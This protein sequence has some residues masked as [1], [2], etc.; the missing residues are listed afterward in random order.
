MIF[1][2]SSRINF[3]GKTNAVRTETCRR[4][5]CSSKIGQKSTLVLN[6]LATYIK[7][8]CDF[9]KIHMYSALF[10]Y[11]KRF[12]VKCWIFPV[13]NGWLFTGCW[14]LSPPSQLG[15]YIYVIA[16]HYGFALEITYK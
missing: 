12:Y 4:F 7:V 2:N 13:G 8:E 10:L 9:K 1:V 14:A 11:I 6:L 5:N 16:N 3:L 15:P